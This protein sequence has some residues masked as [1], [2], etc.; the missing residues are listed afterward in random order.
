M[1]RKTKLAPGEFYHIYSRGNSKQKI[2]LKP[3]DYRR[4]VRLLFLCNTRKQI[5]LRDIPPHKTFKF[6]REETIVDIGCYCLMPNHIHL[7]MKEKVDGGISL[8]MKKL[9][10]AYSMYFNTIN[11]R[12]GVLFEG[13]FKAKH[14]SNDNYL[15]YL[16]AYVHLNPVK[17]TDSKW[18]ESGLQDFRKTKDHLANYQ[19]SSYLDYLGGD[20]EEKSILNVE[21]FPEYFSE[22]RSFDDLINF[23]LTQRTVLDEEM[24]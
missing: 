10:T 8:F 5:L 16:Y 15:K 21:S 7:V 14:A 24:I 17:L 18:K 9:L 3:A 11:K 4:F 20:R 23:W 12:T 1:I 22:K 2:F 19:Y 13:R 6:D